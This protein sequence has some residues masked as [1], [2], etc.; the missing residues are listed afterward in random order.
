MTVKRT[1]KISFKLFRQEYEK[2][3][4][5]SE[6]KGIVIPITFLRGIALLLFFEEE[7]KN[8]KIFF[9]DRKTK[10]VRE[11]VWPWQDKE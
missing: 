4:T 7:V 8:N 11:V 2:I 9:E 6:R 5:F 3:K 10:E 1:V